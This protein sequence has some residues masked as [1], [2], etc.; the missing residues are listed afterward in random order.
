MKIKPI[1]I[2]LGSLLTLDAAPAP[3]V[4][5]GY[6]S[7]YDGTGFENWILLSR[8]GKP[9]TAQNV[10]TPGENK[11]IHIYKEYPDGYQLAEKKNDTHAIMVTKKSYSRYS[12]KFDYKWGTKKLNNF[13]EWQYDA[14]CYFHMID[15]KVWPTALEFQIRYDHTKDKNH[16]ADLWNL[17]VNFTWSHGPDNSYL[18]ESA[19]GT[20]V[21]DRKWEHA[22]AADAKVNALNGQWNEC[23]LIVMGNEYVI[24]KVN[25]KVVNAATKLARDSGP[26]SLQAE[27]AEIFYR[28]IMIK[29]FPESVPMES[30][31]K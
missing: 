8:D 9:E 24:H 19:G 22:A 23:E 12:F 5:A 25:G 17:G 18:A 7:L 26:I 6:T 28:N 4:P 15:Q 31:L 29:E 3:E 11:E 2:L 27:T 20:T 30:L 10:F 21:V 14:G 13:D 1:A 16:T